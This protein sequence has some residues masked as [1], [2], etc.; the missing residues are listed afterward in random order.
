M[1]FSRKPFFNILG[2]WRVATPNYTLFHHYYLSFTFSLSLDSSLSRIYN[3]LNFV[4]LFHF[5][6]IFPLYSQFIVHVS[7]YNNHLPT[8]QLFHSLSPILYKQVIP[9][10]F[11]RTL[12]LRLLANKLYS[13]VV[14]LLFATMFLLLLSNNLLTTWLCLFCSNNCSVAAI[15]NFSHI[16]FI[17]ITPRTQ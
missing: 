1:I 8:K 4:S 3:A 10:S 6:K 9:T 5:S 16:G 14:S 17:E 13:L 2:C 15:N 11:V 12:F 7:Q